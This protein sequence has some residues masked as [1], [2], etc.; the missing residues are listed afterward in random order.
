MW[1]PRF[2]SPNTR[3]TINL[4]KK[5]IIKTFSCWYPSDFNTYSIDLKDQNRNV[6]LTKMN[7]NAIMKKRLSDYT[8]ADVCRVR[9]EIFYLQI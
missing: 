2:A 6:S 7:K 9:F 4:L 1:Y 5:V 8:K 3:L